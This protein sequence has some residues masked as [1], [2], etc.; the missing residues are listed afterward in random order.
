MRS[1]DERKVIAAASLGHFGS[2]FVM[3]ILPALAF[4]LARDFGLSLAS[5]M[6]LAFASYLVYGLGA[7]PAGLLAD[8]FGAHRL[9]LFCF[10]GCSLGCALA[11]ASRNPGELQLALVAIG[12]ASSVYH[13]AG[14]ALITRNVEKSGSALG[15]NGMAGNLGIALA[16]FLAGALNSVAGWRVA[17]AGAAFLMALGFALTLL[18]RPRDELAAPAVRGGAGLAW[19]RFAYGP[20]A[21][22]CIALAVSAAGLGYRAS[23]LSF[24]SFFETR[25]EVLLPAIEWLNSTLPLASH[26]TLAATAMTSLAYLVGMAGQAFGG[27]LADR[28]DL[29]R[30]YA[31]FQL[32]TIPSLAGLLLLPNR[33]LPIAAA[34]YVFFAMGMQP[35]ENSLVAQLVPREQRGLIYGLKFTLTFGVGAFAVY[36]AAA[37][38]R[39]E[40][41][42][43][44]FMFTAAMALTTAILATA[45]GLFERHEQADGPSL[46]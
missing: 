41:V 40:E 10:A 17:Y 9:L 15:T 31:A 12:A 5:I 21:L 27:R 14:M 3:L 8:R 30:G 33:Y 18:L 36:V 35:L 19:P 22:I 6:E 23:S 26:R 44:V 45:S 34:G 11:A 38:T 7:L 32:L 28:V 16:P 46:A 43:P 25:T 20:A 39:G 2:H 13:P 42:S 37:L 1:E 24:P 4:P 29:R